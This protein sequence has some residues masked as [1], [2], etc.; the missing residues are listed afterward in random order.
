MLAKRIMSIA[1][2]VPLVLVTT[3]LGGLWFFL[4]VLLVA[5]VAGREYLHPCTPQFFSTQCLA[6]RFDPQ[7]RGATTRNIWP[8]WRSLPSSSWRSAFPTSGSQRGRWR[9]V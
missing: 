5:L 8:V 2:F 7:T 3:Y 6:Y 4:F 9:E 1:L